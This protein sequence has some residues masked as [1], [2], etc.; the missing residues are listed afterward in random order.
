MQDAKSND[1][2][3]ELI[4]RVRLGH[5]VHIT[6]TAQIAVLCSYLV[7]HIPNPTEKSKWTLS[8][9]SHCPSKLLSIQFPTEFINLVK[10]M[11][12]NCVV[13]HHSLDA[14]AI[15]NWNLLQF[16]TGNLGCWYT[17]KHLMETSDCE[18]WSACKA[19]KSCKGL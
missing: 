13:G 8:Q 19:W 1:E 6:A 10:V 7:N 11:W 14:Q 4:S 9:V 12:W 15:F 5:L 18:F 2:S 17:I 3:R 16:Y